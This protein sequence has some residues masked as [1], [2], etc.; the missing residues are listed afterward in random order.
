M[1]A[2]SSQQW[3]AAVNFDMSPYRSVT[4]ANGQIFSSSLSSWLNKRILLDSI[5]EWYRD[6]WD[7]DYFSIKGGTH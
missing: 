6:V 7:T 3:Q 4:Q 5:K 2:T 1:A